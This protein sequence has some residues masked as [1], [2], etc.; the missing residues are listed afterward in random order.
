[1]N[2]NPSGNTCSFAPVPVF[3]EALSIAKHLIDIDEGDEL[4]AFENMVENQLIS[5]TTAS[6][7]GGDNLLMY[8]VQNA[9]LFSF[10]AMLNALGEDASVGLNHQNWD[11]NTVWHVMALHLHD[12]E[13]LSSGG[14]FNE[15]HDVLND[16]P[17]LSIDWSLRNTLNETALETAQRL[18]KSHLAEWLVMQGAGSENQPMDIDGE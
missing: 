2:I 11:G 6:G 17:S 18:E 1:M 16:L 10:S 7:E 15:V 13:F 4:E 5:G 3:Q 14:W 12:L 8:A 9:A